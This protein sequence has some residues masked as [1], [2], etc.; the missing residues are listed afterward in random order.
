MANPSNLTTYGYLYNWYAAKGIATAGSTTYKNIC[1]TGWHVPTD[2]EWITLTDF[3]GGEYVAGGKMKLMGT[4]YW[5][6]QST[7]TDNSSGFSALPGGARNNDGSF[8]DIRELAYFW[9]TTEYPRDG[10]FLLLFNS[11]SGAPPPRYTP[12]SAGHS[13]RC[14]RD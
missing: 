4:T 12:K 14:L 13:V 7:G 3:L 9:S 2:T 1:H 5:N 11:Y 10:A 8:T 6:L